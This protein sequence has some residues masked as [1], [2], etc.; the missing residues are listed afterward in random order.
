MF[1]A[2]WGRTELA[3]ELIAS[4]AK[5]NSEDDSGQ[6]AIFYAVRGRNLEMV[7]FLVEQGA[8]VAHEDNSRHT[9]LWLAAFRGS[10][11]VVALLLSLSGSLRMVQLNDS[12]S[13]ALGQGH[14]NAAALIVGHAR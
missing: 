1:A 4:G 12:I 11:E 2:F 3:S 10:D 9:A 7:R 13:A 6:T 8:D 14:T 5:V